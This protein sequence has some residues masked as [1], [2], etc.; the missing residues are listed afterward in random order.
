MS[1]VTK[2]KGSQKDQANGYDDDDD[3]YFDGANEKVPLLQRL[4]PESDNT[5]DGVSNSCNVDSDPDSNSGD[6]MSDD[7]DDDGY[8]GYG[9]YNKYD[10]CDR[11][12]YYR[13]RRYERKVLLM[14]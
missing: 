8:N 14:M 7:S 1:S 3:V 10:E 4:Q 11:D 9:E 2:A 13:D 5:H 12:Y 6:K